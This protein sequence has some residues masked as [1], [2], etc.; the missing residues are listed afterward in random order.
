MEGEFFPARQTLWRTESGGGSV[1][2]VEPA[3]DDRAVALVGVRP[4]EVVALGVLD[5]VLGHGAVPDPR[6]RAKRDQAFVLAVDCGHPSGSCFCTSMGSGPGVDEGVDLAVT[7]LEDGPHRFLVRVGSDEG[8]QAMSG[9]AG[10]TAGPDDFAARTRVLEGATAAMG[11]RLETEGLPAL[12]ARNI[13]HPR[14]ADVAERCLSCGNC[15]MVCPTCFCSDVHDTTDLTGETTRQRS[16]SSCFDLDHSYVHG[17]AVRSAT[18]SRYRQWMTH[19][20]STWWDQFDTSGCVGCGRCLTWCPVGIDIT[21]EAAAIRASDGASAE[22]TPRGRRD[23]VPCTTCCRTIRSCAVSVMTRSPWSW[24]AR[25]TWSSTPAEPI[26][27]EGAPADTFY[28]LRRGH[29]SI[30]VHE[31]GRGPIV[32]ETVG[33]DAVIGW[34]WLVPPYRWTFDARALDEVGAVAIDGSCLRAKA[35]GDPAFGFALLTRVTSILW[36]DSRRPAC[37]CSTSTEVTIM[38]DLRLASRAAPAHP[39]TPIVHRVV[40]RRRESDDVVTLVIEPLDGP[41]MAFLPGQFNMLSALGVGEVAISF[42]GAPGEGGVLRHS[43]RDV[44][45]VSG[46]LCRLAVGD[47]VGVRGPFGSDWRLDEVSDDV[48]VVAGGVGLAPLRGAVSEL[49]A[50]RRVN[51]GRVVVLVGARDP[52]QVLFADD[53][54]RWSDEGA[55]VAVTVD[56]A[57]PAWPGRVGLVTGLIAPAGLVA[58]THARPRVRTRDHDALHRAGPP[59]PRDERRLDPRVAGAQHGVRR[60]VVRPLPVR[61]AAARAG[62]VRSCATATWRD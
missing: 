37:D 2:F 6:Y 49:V 4:C 55:E 14:W 36:R 46:A 38:S 61:T 45:A 10:R 40:G 20:L 57:A 17:G 50:R 31:P 51:G 62:T 28:L 30:D 16:W 34:S 35:Q 52:S 53:L 11:R 23:R 44:G 48:V 27:T 47:L 59:G 56:R 25:R 54:A 22:P 60:R 24:G 39:M 12:L 5:G 13:E 1:R 21:E 58:S 29:V 15:T 43:V 9:V 18:A 3:Q 42:S 26:L 41:A 19:K 8:A 7:E 33:A 32:I